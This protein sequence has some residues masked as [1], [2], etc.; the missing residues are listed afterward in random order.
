MI[1]VPRGK[2]DLSL[3]RGIP[4]PLALAPW[5]FGQ[6]LP[7]VSFSSCEFCNEQRNVLSVSLHPFIFRKRHWSTRYTQF[8]MI[9]AGVL[10]G[11]IPCL[12]APFGANTAKATHHCRWVAFLL[13]AWHQNKIKLS[14]PSDELS[15]TVGT[16]RTGNTRRQLPRRA[17]ETIRDYHRI[18]AR[19][20]NSGADE[21]YPTYCLPHKRPEPA[22]E[23]TERALGQYLVPVPQ[24]HSP[25]LR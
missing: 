14:S 18:C 4:S 13:A 17:S 15:F 23:P 10:L 3:Y 9:L 21:T 8:A 25:G 19:Q 1:S 6:L 20:T 11:Q 7:A 2:D 22:Q 24:C 16:F 5:G 12:Y